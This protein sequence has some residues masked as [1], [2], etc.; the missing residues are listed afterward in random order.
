MKRLISIFAIALFVLS[1]CGVAPT[2]RNPDLAQTIDPAC[3]SVKTKEGKL[4]YTEK[5]AK[6]N[7]GG[8]WNAA[9]IETSTC[10][11]NISRFKK[12]TDPKGPA[13]IGEAL[14][15]TLGDTSVWDMR[16]ADQGVKT[17]T[18]VGDSAL[19]TNSTLYIKKNNVVVSLKCVGD[20]ICTEENF[21]TAGK[22][23][24]ERL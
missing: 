17:E 14:V 12:S 7:F 2:P 9:S 13:S 4:I 1:A 8:T 6:A 21:L 19:L 23:I 5:D 18:G 24:A 16:S 3:N 20:K 11:I 10:I 15:V 22:V